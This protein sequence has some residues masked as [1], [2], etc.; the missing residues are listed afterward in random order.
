MKSKHIYILYLII[1]LSAVS[2]RVTKAAPSLSEI[3]DL[4]FLETDKQTVVSIN[5]S[6][7]T[8]AVPF[9]KSNEN[10]IILDFDKTILA[11]SISSRAFA[12]RDIKLAYLSVLDNNS[13]VLNSPKPQNN[14]RVRAKFFLKPDCMTSVKYNDNK[15]LLK[16]VKKEKQE[17]NCLPQNSLLHPKEKKYTPVVLSLENA[18]FKSVVSEIANQA[19]MEINFKG[20]IPQKLSIE[21][22][23]E[24]SFEALCAIAEKSNMN[25][26]R[27]GKNWFLEGERK[28]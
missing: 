28:S 20:E 19:G 27:D 22:Q 2:W 21:L 10:C 3:K 11:E 16:V 23:S 1:L 7:P 26:Y 24:D 12:S 4:N 9:L 14:K 18:P 15:V 5:L 6:K 8:K 13:K 17:K 25:F